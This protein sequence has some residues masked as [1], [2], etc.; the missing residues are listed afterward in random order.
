[1]GTECLDAAYPHKKPD[2]EQD[3]IMATSIS[4]DDLNDTN[5]QA[6]LKLI[7]Y[8][9]HRKEDDGVYLIV[10]GGGRFI[11]TKEHPHIIVYDK[12]DKDKKHPHTPA[13]AY[14]ITFSTWSGAKKLG[15][16]FDFSPAQQ[17]KLAV[18]IIADQGALDDVKAGR[19]EAAYKKLKGQ[20]SSLPGATQTP[21]STDDAKSRFERYLTECS[22]KK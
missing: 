7:R 20:W 13:G 6:F 1:M 21:V 3:V 14:Q 15:V 2:S 17:D 12:S 22:P 11:D 8:C 10:Y 5:V 19:L 18:W 16:V 9:E 4:Q